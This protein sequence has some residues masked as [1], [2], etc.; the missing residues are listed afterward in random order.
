MRIVLVHSP[1]VGPSAWRPVADVLSQLGHEVA[2]PDLRAASGSGDPNRFIDAARAAV[3]PDTDV[4]AGHSGAGFFLPSI[5]TVDANLARLMFVDAGIPPPD[6][7]ATPG[8][9]F[10]G[11]LRDLSSGGRLPR[12][13]QWWGD[14]A[15][16]RLV[17][18]T[19]LRAE[20]EAELVEVPLGFYEQTVELPAGWR[21]APA[22]LL[23]LSESYRADAA[24][25]RSLGWPVIER[26]GAHLDVA[27][28]PAE[29][30]R[31]LL[32]LHA[33]LT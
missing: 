21:A 13:S 25:A 16:E 4:I 29:I 17:P 3:A 19:R 22:G 15:M 30:A 27:N 24:T 12:W 7:S 9:D 18:D 14:G 33:N 26:L 8:G 11:R 28:H 5:A 10:I 2:L 31:M 23:L 32:D 20:I 6:G 1:L